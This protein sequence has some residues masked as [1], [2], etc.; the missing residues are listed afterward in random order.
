MSRHLFSA[1]RLV[2]SLAVA[3]WAINWVL[4]SAGADLKHEF[5][6]CNWVWIALAIF[7]TGVGTALSS[8]R[9]STLLAL[10]QVKITQW[11]AFRLTMIGIF[12]NLFGLGGVGGDFFKAFYVRGHAGEHKAEAMLSILVD[13]ILGLLGLFLVALL[14]LPFVWSELRQAPTQVQS[15][16]GFVVLVSVVGGTGVTLVL[17]RDLWLPA[18]SKEGMKKL[19]T[20]LPGKVYRIVEKLVR[21]LDLYRTQLP[22]L[23][24]ALGLSAFVHTLATLSVYSVGQAFHIR[25]VGMRFYFLGVQV[26]NTISAVPITPSG[27]GS[28]DLVL[29]EFLIK[30]GGGPERCG[31]IPFG[32][33]CIIVL[34][35]LVGGIFFVMA[36]RSGEV[37]AELQEE[38]QDK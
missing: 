4:A 18:S 31:L 36:R 32:L 15:M 6:T 22:Q 27:L 28:R 10:Q 19:G 23:F 37:P 3:A 25:E 34:W 13:R 17:S 14:S 35:S 8:Y 12:F 38:E 26:A 1:L 30:L 21:S 16:T 24:K 33:S 11:D 7:L 9:W 5:Q 29:K 2:F 20:H